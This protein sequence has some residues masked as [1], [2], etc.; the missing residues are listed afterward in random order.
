MQPSVGVLG[1]ARPPAEAHAR[2]PAAWARL[3]LRLQGLWQ[4]GFAVTNDPWMTLATDEQRRQRVLQQLHRTLH[5]RR[6]VRLRSR[7][8]SRPGTPGTPAALAPFPPASLPPSLPPPP[9][10]AASCTE[11]Q[12]CPSLRLL[13]TFPQAAT[14]H[15]RVQRQLSDSVQEA[16]ADAAA[17][18]AAAAGPPPPLAA[19]GGFAALQRARSD[20]R[21]R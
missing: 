18:A 5:R 12:P 10:P 6:E 19:G 14:E 11:R 3:V 16:A 2:T 4:Q 13:R 21:L 1:S 8:H 9:P 17:V 7:V 15:K 20:T